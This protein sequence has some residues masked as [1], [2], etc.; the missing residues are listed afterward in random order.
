[1]ITTD[2]KRL[3]EFI[4]NLEKEF[5]NR[6]KDSLMCTFDLA[7]L[8]G[9]AIG[10]LKSINDELETIEKFNNTLDI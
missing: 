6:S 5:E 1:M 4:N 3:T 2:S 7:K 10:M 8:Y 9:K